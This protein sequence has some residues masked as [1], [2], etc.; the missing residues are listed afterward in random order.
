MNVMSILEIRAVHLG[1]RAEH[2]CCTYRGCA[3]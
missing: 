1:T 2:A 3:V